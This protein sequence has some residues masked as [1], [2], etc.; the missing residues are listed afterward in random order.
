MNHILPHFNRETEI[1]SVPHEGE[2]FVTWC[3]SY[4]PRDMHFLTTFLKFR[5]NK[6]WNF[7]FTGCLPIKLTEVLLRYWKSFSWSSNS[8]PFMELERSLLCSKDT[9]TASYPDPVQFSPHSLHTTLSWSLWVQ[10]PIYSQASKTAFKCGYNTILKAT[11]K[12]RVRRQIMWALANMM[13]KNVTLHG[14]GI[15]YIEKAIIN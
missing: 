5:E 13:G 1:R 12:S 7:N 11:S 15:Y 8:S 14:S 10:F 3:W 2:T 9:D 6:T 4:L